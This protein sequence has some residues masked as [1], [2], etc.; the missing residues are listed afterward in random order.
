VWEIAMFRRLLL[1]T[2]TVLTLLPAAPA[3]AATRSSRPARPAS[4]AVSSSYTVH[5]RR[6]GSASWSD[7]RDYASHEEAV[8]ATRALYEKGFE[9]ELLARTT[10]TRPP[11]RVPRRAVGASGA[12]SLQQAA[13]VFRWMAAQKDIAFRFPI[14]GCYARAHLMCRRMQR[15][16]LRPAKVW[17]FAL[18]KNEP[19]YVRTRNRPKGYVTWGWHVAPILPVRLKNGKQRWYVIDPSLFN[20]PVTIA[21]WRDKQ[22]FPNGRT[23]PYVT[24]SRFGQAPV[25]VHGRR[26]PGSGYLPGPDPRGGVDAHAVATMRRYKPW[27]GREPPASVLHASSDRPA[28]PPG[29][30]LAGILNRGRARAA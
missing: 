2:L 10:L 8:A 4:R 9:V 11:S 23:R 1:S 7:Y 24:V 20:G 13:S 15:R 19:L 21:Q 25:D 17:A 28:L 22:R 3:Q 16:G 29:D 18:S 14:D 30:R 26:L 6:P 27:E 5:Y 12:I